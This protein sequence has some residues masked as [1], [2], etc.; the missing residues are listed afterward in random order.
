[1]YG[2]PVGTHSFKIVGEWRT[3]GST[4]PLSTNVTVAY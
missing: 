1:V 4:I 2:V 3:G